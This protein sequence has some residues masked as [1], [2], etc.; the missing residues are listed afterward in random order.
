[1]VQESFEYKTDDEQFGREKYFFTED[2]L[3]YPFSDCED[4]SI[5]FSHLVRKLLGLEVVGLNY[6][7]H[8]A[9][10]VK[11]NTN[12]TGDA[13]LIDNSKYIIC[14]P[15]YIGSDVGMAMPQFKNVSPS[16]IRVNK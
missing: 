4:R 3:Y 13:L 14:D 16:V 5:F 1:M 12:V 9:T 11:F 7:N 6:P 10:A 2:I 15:T 8:V